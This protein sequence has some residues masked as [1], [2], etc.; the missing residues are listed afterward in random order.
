MIEI[1]RITG[2]LMDSSAGPLKGSV[3]FTPVIDGAFSTDDGSVYAGKVTGT[4]GADGSV[5]IPIVPSSSVAYKISFSLVTKGNEPVTLK[6]VTATITKSMRIT[7]L[8]TGSAGVVTGDKAANVAPIRD[9]NLSNAKVDPD[10][11][12]VFIITTH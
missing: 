6:P 2:F 9:L 11:P 10:D 4:V 12:S 5:N 3:S 1:A 8:I 7:D